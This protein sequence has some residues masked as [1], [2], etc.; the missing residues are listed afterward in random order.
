MIGHGII[1]RLVT[2]AAG[3][4]ILT[5]FP[6]TTT[7]ASIVDQSF[8]DLSAPGN[9]AT[10]LTGD[11]LLAQ[12]FTVGTGGLLTGADILAFDATPEFGS[13]APPVSDMVVQIR[14]FS[15][16]LPTATILASFTVPASNLLVNPNGQFT[17]VDFATGV[18]VVPG[19]VLGLSISGAGVGWD[20]Q[21]GTAATY[22]DGQ[23]FVRPH[24]GYAWMPLTDTGNRPS[25]FLFR[26]YV[27]VPEPS[28]PSLVGCSATMLFLASRLRLNRRQ[29][30]GGRGRSEAAP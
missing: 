16:G 9:T 10:S 29:P 19:Q 23:G 21:W 2:M 1:S 6:Q 7:A 17:H 3:S 27:D 4:L 12:S 18:P 5:S 22:P 14:G 15:A 28:V 20:L 11:S 30:D 25:D 13:G 24:E 8:T 26:T